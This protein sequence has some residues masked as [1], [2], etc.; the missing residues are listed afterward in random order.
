MRTQEEKVMS[1]QARIN[2]RFIS[3]LAGALALYA[4]PALCNSFPGIGNGDA[5]CTVTVGPTNC[6]VNEGQ[7]DSLIELV[8]NELNQNVLI[9][10]ITSGPISAAVPDPTD[11]I[12][13][14]PVSFF[15]VGYAAFPACV[16]GVTTLAAAGGTCYFVQSFTT[17]TPGDADDAT[18]IPN[19]GTSNMSFNLIFTP[20][21]V[22]ALPVGSFTCSN[23]QGNNI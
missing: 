22:P 9:N 15:Q 1:L 4:L 2:F 13:S 12:T 3:H 14:D 23:G 6:T 10:N 5:L 8:V 19:D 21:F 18:N 7:G 20:L 16:P 17:G 11:A